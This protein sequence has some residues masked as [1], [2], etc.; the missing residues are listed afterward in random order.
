MRS[1]T[2]APM[3]DAFGQRVLPAQDFS[4]LKGPHAKRM[5]LTIILHWAGE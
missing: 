5:R 1:I 4:W 2:A 3:N